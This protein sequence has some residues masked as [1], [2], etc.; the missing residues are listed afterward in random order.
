MIKTSESWKLNYTINS[1]SKDT[2][3]TGP[4]TFTFEIPYT[5]SGGNATQTVALVSIENTT[6]TTSASTTCTN[7]LLGIC[8]L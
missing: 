2:T 8:N 4:G 1:V 7:T 5:V 6:A 3:G